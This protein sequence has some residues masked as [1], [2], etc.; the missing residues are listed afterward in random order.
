MNKTNILMAFM[1]FMSL[2]N[3]VMTYSCFEIQQ[4][5]FNDVYQV[6]LSTIEMIEKNELN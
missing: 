3:M 4:K 6:V 2:A 1:I 5:Q